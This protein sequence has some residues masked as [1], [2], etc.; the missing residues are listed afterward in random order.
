M[1]TSEPLQPNNYD[2]MGSDQLTLF[3]V[4]SHANHLAKPGSD[5]ASQM[6]VTS[7]R[8]CSELY[9]KSSPLGLLVKTLLGSSIWGSNVRL[10]T[11][12]AKPTKSNRLLFQLSPSA[13]HTEGTGFGLLPTPSA[14]MAGEGPLLDSLETKSGEKA[15]LGER[16][17]N[18]K[19][20]KHVQITINRAVK[21]W[22][23]PTTRDHKG[24][25]KP[26]AMAAKGRNPMTNSLGDAI[27][28]GGVTG[29]LNP[30]WVEWLMGF[31]EGWTDLKD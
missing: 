30:T 29:R 8:K 10:L 19:T 15:K 12:K 7:G 1:K 26:E 28:E 2:P 17:Y 18:P 14:Q 21:M 23:T 9:R 11:W 22:P 31:P 4:D 20:G 25:R 3:A 24:A 13:H 16:A 6:T 27:G 5:L